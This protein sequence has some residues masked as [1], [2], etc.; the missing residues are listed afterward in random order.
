[1]ADSRDKLMKA[2][3][4]VLT[5]D[6]WYG[7]MA[8]QMLWKLDDRVGTMGVRIMS[9][10]TVECLWSEEFVKDL[11]I[12]QIMGVV[13][14]E[15]EH[16]VR[17]HIVRCGSKAPYIWNLA[18][19]ACINGT[20]SNPRIED[21]PDGGIWMPSNL[22]RDSTAEEVYSWL[23]QQVKGKGKC[24]S[25]NGKGSTPVDSDGGGGPCDCEAE[26]A[27]QIMKGDTIDNHDIW[28]ESTMGEDLARQVVK[29]MC[30]SASRN[31]GT[32]PGHLIGAIE[33]LRE[34]V[35]NW[36][37]M[38]R[39]F[40]GRVAGGKRKTYSRINRRS[41]L[42]GSKGKSSHASTKLCIFVDTSGSVGDKEIQQFFGEIESMSQYFK[43]WVIQFD[44]EFQACDLY[45]RGDWN[46]IKIHGR[47]GT[48]F[49]NICN[50][51]EENQMIGRANIMLT[52][53]YAQM[54]ASFPA[55]MIWAMTTDVEA[56]DWAYGSVRVEV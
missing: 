38:L 56:P 42:F 30:E 45:H 35:V 46:R 52:D 29:D 7:S 51:A 36:K 50:W 11:D 33:D 41:Q 43:I 13:K 39:Q 47:G 27:K 54:P 3:C 2:R 12:A 19:D 14:H 4:R 16:I 31:A 53:G 34:P 6:P 23:M 5:I 9:N 28:S 18:T 49:I 22:D 10:G 8:A 37:Y 32:T 1:M 25:C 40:V 48:S 15:I 20:K 21:L 17:M 55:P 24:P 44:Y 26:K